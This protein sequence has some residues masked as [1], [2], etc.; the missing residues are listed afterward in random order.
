MKQKLKKPV[1]KTCNR[2][3]VLAAYF[4]SIKSASNISCDYPFKSVINSKFY[5]VATYVQYFSVQSQYTCTVLYKK[6]KKS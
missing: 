1:K 4:Q 2:Y 3:K 6:Y 5:A